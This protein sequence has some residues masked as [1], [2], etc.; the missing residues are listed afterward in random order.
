MAKS[1]ENENGEPDDGGWN[2]VEEE[3]EIGP[4][5]VELDQ[6]NTINNE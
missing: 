3:P 6:F 5:D 4:E 2:D 1:F